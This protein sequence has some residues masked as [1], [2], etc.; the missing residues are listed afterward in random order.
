[1]QTIEK[2]P[3]IKGKRVL[4]RVDFNVPIFQEKVSEDFR[5]RASLPTLKFLHKKGAKIILLSHRKNPHGKIEENLRL[6]PIALRLEEILK[7]KIQK[8]DDCIG[9][10]AIETIEKLKNG[11]ILLLE[12]VRFHE[13]ELKNTP[14]FAKQLAKLADFFVFDAFGVAHRQHASVAGVTKI[15]PS[16]LGYSVTQEMTEL[17][18]V[19]KNPKKPLVLVLGGAKIETK[20]GVLRRFSKI[21]DSILLGGGIANTFLAAQGFEIGESLYEPEKIELAQ[22]ILIQAEMSGCKFELPSDVIC[23]NAMEKISA[24]SQALTFLI[25]T[26]PSEMKILDCG[27]QTAKKFSSFIQ[28]AKTV[29]WNGPLG[30]FEFPQFAH[31]TQ[32]VAQAVAKTS[33]RTILGGGDT[34]EALKRFKIP[35]TKITHVSTG[36]GAMLKFLEGEKLEIEN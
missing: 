24:K 7:E 32:T 11:E 27:E 18:Q 25:D 28:K 13:G 36:G 31:A 26:I 22:E 12:N 4:V 20:I 5:I 19:F 1:L 23:T 9:P 15:L 10:K 2:L 30:L 34:L 35:Q 29:V 3:N 21:A 17:S 8:T 6:D 14:E 33:A 16:Y